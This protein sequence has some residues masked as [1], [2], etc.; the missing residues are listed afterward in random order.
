MSCFAILSESLRSKLCGE[1]LRS[2]ELLFAH[3]ASQ[4]GCVARQ[5][6]DAAGG[7]GP[8]G[9]GL[10]VAKQ[11]L[12]LPLHCHASA[13]PFVLVGQVAL[14]IGAVSRRMWRAQALVTR[15]LVAR[16]TI[17]I[18]GSCTCC[19]G[20]EPP[21]DTPRPYLLA[22]AS[23]QRLPSAKTAPR[24]R[25]W[26]CNVSVCRRHAVSRG[27]GRLGAPHSRRSGVRRAGGWA[28]WLR[29]AAA[30]TLQLRAAAAPA[31]WLLL[32]LLHAGCCCYA[33]LSGRVV[34]Q[35]RR[36]APRRQA[37][38]HRAPRRMWAWDRTECEDCAEGSTM[39]D[40]GWC[41]VSVYRRHAVSRG[42]GRLGAPHSERTHSRGAPVCG[43]CVGAS[44]SPTRMRV[45]VCRAHNADASDMLGGLAG[46]G[47][48]AK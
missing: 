10:L 45:V 43:A 44:R 40:E 37:P 20:H 16:R 12:A 14:G 23:S 41:N 22:S 18:T 38:R 21:H 39:E 2:A 24:D 25:Q 27:L 1:D 9:L 13:P 19:R 11:G 6:S 4:L 30:A 8:Q 29:L 28:G 5:G 34:L 46:S 42:V 35:L 33:V 32:L 31:R 47:C 36:R 3:V 17:R 15:A 48:R 7:R 26:M